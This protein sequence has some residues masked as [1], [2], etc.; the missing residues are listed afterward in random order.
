MQR[1]LFKTSAISLLAIFVLALGFFLKNNFYLVDKVEARNDGNVCV[2][3]N[4][5]SKFSFTTPAGTE[6]AFINN[7]GQFGFNGTLYSQ[8]TQGAV[9]DLESERE[10]GYRCQDFGNDGDYTNDYFDYRIDNANGI[11]TMAVVYCRAGGATKVFVKRI[12]REGQ[13]DGAGV[14]NNLDLNGSNQFILL[15]SAGNIVAGIDNVGGTNNL[16]LAGCYQDD[17]AF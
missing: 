12:I 4:N 6:F 10:F 16:V 3:T 14:M 11:T 5:G 9:L 15:S 7:S 17:F 8:E 1:F 2:A 13:F